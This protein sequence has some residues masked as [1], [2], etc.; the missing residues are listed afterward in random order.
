MPSN[1]WESDDTRDA[2]SSGFRKIE[3]RPVFG[4]D[5]VSP[6]AD[7]AQSTAALSGESFVFA[8]SIEFPSYGISEH[9]R[10]VLEVYIQ[11]GM[12]R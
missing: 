1:L 4:E 7:V 3:P 11:G 2:P 10:Q 9:C 8:S 5:S 12:F 6:S